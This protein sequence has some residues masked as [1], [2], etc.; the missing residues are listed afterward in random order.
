MRQQETLTRSVLKANYETNVHPSVPLPLMSTPDVQSSRLLPVPTGKHF[1][2]FRRILI[3]KYA[4]LV[5]LS[6]TEDEGT[7]IVHNFGSH[8]SIK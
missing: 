6:D 7:T 8:F 5:G 4:T 3:F 2:T 1:P